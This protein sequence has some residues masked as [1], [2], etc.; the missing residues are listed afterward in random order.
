MKTTN[1]KAK[2]VDPKTLYTGQ[3]VHY[4]GQ[5]VRVVEVEYSG[6]V[7]IELPNGGGTLWVSPKTLTL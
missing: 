6:Q 7:C 4:K 2:A 1:T 3:T 5:K